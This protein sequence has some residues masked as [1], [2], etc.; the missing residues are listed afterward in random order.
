[1]TYYGLVE[2]ADHLY[3]PKKRYYAAK[4][5]Y[6]FVQ[7][8]A[9]RVASSSDSDS[10]LISSFYDGGRDAVILVGVKQGGPHQVELRL[11]GSDRSP[12]SW[13]LYQ[14]TRLLNC[15]K[16][17]TIITKNGVANIELPD[18]SVFTLIGKLSGNAKE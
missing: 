6:H 14:T 13:E 1:M 15:A 10:L 4:Q 9:R 8:G 12:G 5:L 3:S 7:P 11:N 2:N 17:D 18:E 16:S